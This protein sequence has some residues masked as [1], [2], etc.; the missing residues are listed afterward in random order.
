MYLCDDD[1]FI[2]RG[3]SPMTT[4]GGGIILASH[5]RKHRRYHEKTL[6]GLRRRWRRETLFHEDEEKK[7]CAAR[8]S[9]SFGTITRLTLCV[10][11]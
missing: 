10:R 1:R 6:E 11:A 7:A 4:I 5:S 9:E 2:I 3:F 8:Y